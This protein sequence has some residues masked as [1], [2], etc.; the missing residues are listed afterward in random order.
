[1][2]LERMSAGWKIAVRTVPDLDVR[3][4]LINA[5]K[6]PTINID[7]IHTA[8]RY[9]RYLRG[10]GTGSLFA[11]HEEAKCWILWSDQTLF[12]SFIDAVTF[13]EGEG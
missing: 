13:D 3:G 2:S 1:M 7:S 6:D 9:A 5:G 11:W 4:L 10:G 8:D 12:G